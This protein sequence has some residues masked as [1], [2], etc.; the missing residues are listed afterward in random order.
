MLTQK[1]SQNFKKL[2]VVK[3]FIL[4]TYEIK[5]YYILEF[6]KHDIRKFKRIKFKSGFF[7]TDGTLNLI[8]V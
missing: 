7:F 2:R 6:I 3:F 4:S 5:P 8:N 1:V